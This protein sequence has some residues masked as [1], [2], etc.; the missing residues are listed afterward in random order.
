MSAP[1]VDAQRFSRQ[2][3][4]LCPVCGGAGDDEQKTGV[5]CWGF[6]SSGFV[7][8]TREEYAKGIPLNTDGTSSYTHVLDKPCRCG[9]EHPAPTWWKPTFTSFPYENNGLEVGVHL[10]WDW[11]DGTKTMAW[12]GLKGRRVETLPLWGADLLDTIPPGSTVVV[13]EGE[14]KVGMLAKFDIAAV[15][16]ATG[17]P[18]THEADAF[19]VLLP[20][21]VIC[22]GDSKDRGPLQ[23]QANVARLQEIGH[24]DIRII[25]AGTLAPDDFIKAG[26]TKEQIEAMLGQSGPA[27]SPVTGWQW[28]SMLRGAAITRTR[29][30]EPDALIKGLFTKNLQ[31]AIVGA[32]GSA[33]SW[34]L[35][36]LALGVAHPQITTF[37]GQPIMLHGPVLL[38]SWEQG[39][40]E[41]TRR[42]QKILYGYGIEEASENLIQVSNPAVA[43]TDDAAFQ[44]RLKDMVEAGVVLYA[45]DSLS[46]GCGIELN[47]NTAYTNWWR[48]RVYPIL[49]AGITV[50]FTHLRGHVQNKP[51]V[52]PDRDSVFRGAT[53]IRAL[54]QAAIECR[55]TGPNSS[56][57]RHNKHRDTPELPLGT[58]NLIGGFEEPGIKLDL[59]APIGKD[60]VQNA[61]LR[62][63]LNW[64]KDNPKASKRQIKAGLGMGQ[65]T[66]DALVTDAAFKGLIRALGPENRQVWSIAPESQVQSEYSAEDS[67]EESDD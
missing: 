3:D 20:F 36:E 31:H 58:L 26:K 53:Q 63:L 29:V 34:L 28:G 27:T 2:Q 45:F 8:C 46:E 23:Q 14:K 37:L 18:A 4:R 51:G 44:A 40:A 30:I 5:R 39:H 41:D 42:S 21:K 67:N 52:I 60:V 59:V 22:W 65:D 17:A 55:A 38:E 16:I 56:L 11:P 19:K 35:W 50:V 33:K 66:V 43:L 62:T 57:L 54:T 1:I 13:V 64:L 12:S 32:S 15:G 9:T 25:P 7:R 24:P 47:D 49:Q 61:K 48:T 10:R 6:V